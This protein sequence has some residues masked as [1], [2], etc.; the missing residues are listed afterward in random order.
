MIIFFIAGFLILALGGCS[1]E[2]RDAVSPQATTQSPSEAVREPTPMAVQ[3]MPPPT[4]GAFEM[5]GT[6]P[7]SP[8]PP[9]VSLGGAAMP[10]TMPAQPQLPPTPPSAATT[11]PSETPAG[12]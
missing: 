12:Y 2:K 7:V 5:A 9:E 3:P 1:F 10:S 11:Q 6:V 4:P 8:V